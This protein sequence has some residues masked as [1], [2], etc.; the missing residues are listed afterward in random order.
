MFKLDRILELLSRLE[1]KL[2]LGDVGEGEVRIALELASTL[3]IPLIRALEYAARAWHI[4]SG[5]AGLD[6]ISQTII[7]ILSSCRSMG[8]IE[9]YRGVKA[10]RGRASRRIVSDRVKKLEAMGIVI[11]RRS[12]GRPK[13]LLKIC[14]ERDEKLER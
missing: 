12:K 5:L 3:S 8:V 1:E 11:S 6:P 9:I 13:Y 14:M 7:K 2:S 4:I 10:V